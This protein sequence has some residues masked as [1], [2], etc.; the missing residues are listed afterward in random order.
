[1]SLSLRTTQSSAGLIVLALASFASLA[2]LGCT[3]EVRYY[4]DYHHDYH[5]WNH[6][7]V[8]IYQSY[9]DGRREH[10]REFSTLSPEE[11]R[12]YWRWRH[13]HR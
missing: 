9:W 4:D 6:H 12:E 3:G 13:E 8:V 2:G 5:R 11:Q 1:M 7:E 10:Y